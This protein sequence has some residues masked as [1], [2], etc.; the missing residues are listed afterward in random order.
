MSPV[1]RRGLTAALVIA[2]ALALGAPALL[3]QQA[4][5]AG[6]GTTPPI[7]PLTMSMTAPSKARVGQPITYTIRIQ[8]ISSQTVRNVDICERFDVSVTQGSLEKQFR[9][10]EIRPGQVIV[11]L[12]H[13][14]TPNGTP[15]G[16]TVYHTQY[17]A[18]V[19]GVPG[20]IGAFAETLET[21]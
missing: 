9:I 5:A 20:G 11:R 1:T 3:D 10:P 4:G 6:A 16:Q 2:A 19:P 17:M 18:M 15:N 13:D 7:F 8:N 21:R 12:I 14:G